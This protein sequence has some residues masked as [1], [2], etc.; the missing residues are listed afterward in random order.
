MSFES[1]SIIICDEN[2]KS[3][4]LKQNATLNKIIDYTFISLSEFKKRYEYRITNEGIIY[5]MKKLSLSYKNTLSIIENIYYIKN[6]PYED[7]KYKNDKKLTDLYDLKEELA[8]NNYLEFDPLFK[9]NIKGKKIYVV[10]QFFDLYTKD[11]FTEV[12]KY[13]EVIYVENKL[14]QETIL[15]YKKFNK[16]NQEVEWV[17]NNILRFLR[18]GTDIN[19]IYIVNGNKDYNHLLYRYSNLYNIPIHLRE[20]ESILNHDKV[21]NFLNKLLISDVNTALKEVDRKEE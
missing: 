20:S 5:A 3:T 12:E 21:Q 10:D 6:N 18:K 16:F 19:N 11:L 7:E 8:K 17:F 1:K 2:T 15:R 14:D 9:K 4:I 13:S